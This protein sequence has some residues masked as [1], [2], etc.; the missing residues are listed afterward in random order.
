MRVRRWKGVASRTLGAR[1]VILGLALLVATVLATPAILAYA[2]LNGVEP[3][4]PEECPPACAGG[5]VITNPEAGAQTYDVP[6]L[7]GEEIW[8]NVDDGDGWWV[9][10][11][12]D[13]PVV[14][15]AITTDDPQGPCTVYSF[16]TDPLVFEYSHMHSP[17][18]QRPVR[19]E[20][21]F[22]GGQIVVHKFEDL[23][24]DGV[25]DD[26]EP[27]LEDWGFTLTAVYPGAAPWQVGQGSTNA[28]GELLFPN[29]E[30]SQ[31]SGGNDNGG[32]VSINYIVTET[33][34]DGWVSTTGVTQENI[35]VENRETTHV[36]FGN[37]R[38]EEPGPP[39]P[40]PEP[41]PEPEEEAEP[42]VLPKTG[43]DALS[44]LGFAAM[45]AS[46]GTAM[47]VLSRR[48]RH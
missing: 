2:Q 26:G 1:A 30:P 40:T 9:D 21:C 45:F 38:E 42:V 17:G 47:R 24:R 48:R 35:L 16:G 15:V 12:S 4:Y 7:A 5:L 32:P 6:G 33:L 22:A 23:D 27:M 44:V 20:I 34:P 31:H 3:T 37:A 14:R 8:V 13:V 25:Y 28:N 41:E 18:W 46:G 10:F 36:W 29:L 11:E 39:E 43:G 19:I